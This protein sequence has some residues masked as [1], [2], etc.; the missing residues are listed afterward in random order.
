MFFGLT[1]TSLLS[2]VM[3]SALFQ[4][5]ARAGWIDELDGIREEALSGPDHEVVN[6]IASEGEDLWTDLRAGGEYSDPHEISSLYATDATLPGGGE[7]PAKGRGRGRGRGKEAAAEAPAPTQPL[8]EAVPA[9]PARLVPPVVAAPAPHHELAEPAAATADIWTPVVGEVPTG[10]VVV[11]EPAPGE[12]IWVAPAPHPMRPREMWHPAESEVA[13][14]AQEHVGTAPASEPAA[15]GPA[16][17]FEPAAFAPVAEPAF[18]PAADHAFAPAADPAFE[19]HAAATAA[20]VHTVAE[21]SPGPSWDVEPS[22][23][24]LAPPVGRRVRRDRPTHRRGALPPAAPAT[25]DPFGPLGDVAEHSAPL[26]QRGEQSPLPEVPLP[27]AAF[28]APSARL[29]RVEAP[30]PTPPAPAFEQA[31]EQVFEASASAPAQPLRSTPLPEELPAPMA[32]PAFQDLVEELPAPAP[33]VPHDLIEALPAPA[34]EPAADAPIEPTPLAIGDHGIVPV[35]GTI[36]RVGGA[37]S[38]TAAQD[39]H[40]TV[41]SLTEGWTWVAP[42]DGPTVEVHVEVPV[43]RIT[44]AADATGLAV[45][46]A[47]GS[48]FVIVASGAAQLVHGSDRTDLGEGTIAMIDR[49]GSVQVDQATQDEVIAD[50][51]VELNLSLDAEL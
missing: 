47:D 36:V 35:A 16:P 11:G 1:M 28:P 40:G 8:P 46:E 21:G 43:G 9:E 23:P 38:A 15:T 48:S 17:V 4:R 5:K 25:I 12:P 41:V 6:A 51:V 34:P 27:P 18:A 2:L 32:E 7:K 29:P 49:L 19:P 39:H 26:P 31:F 14:L 37:A 3:S 10:T 33:D 20:P 13:P 22:A 45:V 44:F 30:A 24:V 42:G 50:P